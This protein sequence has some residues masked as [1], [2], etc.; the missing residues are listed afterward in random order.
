MPKKFQGENSKAAVA[1]ARKDAAKQEEHDRQQKAFEDALWMDDDKHVQRKQQRKDDKMKKKQETAHRKAENRAMAEE[2]MSALKGTKSAPT[3]VTHAE[4]FAMKDQQNK[5]NSRISRELMHDE[6]PLEENVNVISADV[7]DARN[8]DDAIAV[9]SV[10]DPEVDHHP[11]KR[12]KAAYQSF[13]DSNL[14]RLK[15]ENPNLRL[16]QLKQIL[17]KEWM[18][19]SENPMNQRHGAYN[20]K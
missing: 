16:S 13:E 14:P 18:K 3:K 9:L 6:K 1:R 4:I 17:K 8:I 15:A 2:E 10:K 19:S 7:L 5:V 20:A 12:M 11:E